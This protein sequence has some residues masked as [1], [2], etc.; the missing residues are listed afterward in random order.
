MEIK[1]LEERHNEE[2]RLHQVKL[3]QALQ[4][5][6]T[7]MAKQLDRVT[8]A[9][10][11]EVL[12][13]INN[14]KSPTVSNNPDVT[15]NQLNILKT[16]SHSNLEEVLSVDSVDDQEK[17]NI[18]SETIVPPLHLAATTSSIQEDSLENFA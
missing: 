11:L 17:D 15:I 4:Q 2:V 18:T 3:S 13:I 14:G 5:K 10:W 16:K 9:Q 12:K 1:L 7:D 6:K 8:E